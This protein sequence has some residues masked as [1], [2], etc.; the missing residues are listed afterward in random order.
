MTAFEYNEAVAHRYDAAV[1]VTDEEI[2]FYL[3]YA[4]DAQARGEATL[5]LACGTGRV[6]IP[7]A[8]EDVQI[9]GLDNSSAMLERAREKSVSMDNVRW[10]EGDMRDF[11][12]GERF[13]LI[14]IPAGS[15]HL[16]AKTEEQ[17][18]C[19][20]SAAASMTDEG[21]LIIDLINP[22]IPGLGET[23]TTKAGVLTRRA[24]RQFRDPASGLTART[25]ESHQYH[26]SRQ[27]LVITSVVDE[28]DDDGTVVNRR[29]GTMT[30]RLLFRYEVE[31]LLARCRL[32]VEA[33][34]GG[35]DRS[36]YRGAS[37]QMLVVARRR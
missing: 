28:T 33:M 8:G 6:A 9:V 30:L 15:F 1:P 7:L 22:S 37:R 23:L 34:Y 4:R 36:A 35:F 20:R 13:G 11:A 32:T 18:G 17:L 25:W 19:L 27:E 10:I 26:P 29:Y 12:L 5:E 21:R 2:A 3:H 24:D 31:H 14:T 16:L